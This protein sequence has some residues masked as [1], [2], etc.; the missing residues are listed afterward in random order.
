ML[1]LTRGLSRG[2]GKP[3]SRVARLFIE[4]I[5]HVLSVSDLRRAFIPR[6]RQATTV[7]EISP[8]YCS[9]THRTLSFTHD[10]SK[11]PQ[12]STRACQRLF[13]CSGKEAQGGHH[14]RLYETEV[15][16]SPRILS[17]VL[18]CCNVLHLIGSNLRGLFVDSYTHLFVDSSNGCCMIIKD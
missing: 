15:S 17:H 5:R 10:A 18:K 4:E 11:C 7:Q 12:K 14:S 6:L 16:S 3:N 9:L 13:L 1:T 2:P 8:C